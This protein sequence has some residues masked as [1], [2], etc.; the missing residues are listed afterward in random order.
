MNTEATIIKTYLGAKVREADE[1]IRALKTQLDSLRARREY[2]H[3]EYLAFE[4][5]SA[6]TALE[7]VEAEPESG[8]Q[9]P[10]KGEQGSK[11]R[12]K[13][14]RKKDPHTKLVIAT[15][16]EFLSR[17][18]RPIHRKWILEELQSTPNIFLGA[19]RPINTLSAYLTT[20]PQF[21]NSH[22]GEGIWSLREYVD[23]PPI[24]EDDDLEVEL[25]KAEEALSAEEPL[26]D[27]VQLNVYKA[28]TKERSTN[29]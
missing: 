4:G 10:P 15:T 5:E 22:P 9:E 24:R 17:V 26:P 8:V 29:A 20:Y 2:L 25:A 14:G 18:A 28:A 7:T 23:R 19:S 1:E 27:V 13:R 21:V 16:E 6:I 12:R 3:G 11:P